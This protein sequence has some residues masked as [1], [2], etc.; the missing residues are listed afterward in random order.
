MCFSEVMVLLVFFSIF[1]F[2]LLSRLLVL[3]INLLVWVRVVLVCLFVWVNCCIIV[4][5]FLCLV[6]SVLVVWLRWLRVWLM[7]VVF[8]LESRLLKCVMSWLMLFIR[9]LLLFSNW[10]SGEGVV[11]IIGIFLFLFFSIGLVGVLLLS[12]MIEV[13]VI[14]VSV[15]LVVVFCLIGVL[16]IMWMCV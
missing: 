4:L 8:F 7:C 10:V 1:L 9:F 6:E 15:S 16:V 14:L 5:M 12:W 13:L 11:M 3:C 2:C